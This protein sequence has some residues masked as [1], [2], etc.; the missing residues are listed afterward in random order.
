MK[1][2]NICKF[3]MA[4]LELKSLTIT[5]FVRET[6]EETMSRAVRLADN[7]MLLCTCGS[8]I[9]SIDGVKYNIRSGSL[10]VC[11][12]GEVVTVESVDGL[13]Y[14]YIGFTGMRS[15]ELFRRFDITPISRML[16]G[17]DGLIPLWQESLFSAMDENLDIVAE[18]LLLFSFSRMHG[19]CGRECGVISRIVEMTEE[20]FRDCNVNISYIADK[21]SYN[22]KYLSHLF[23]SKTGVGYSEYLRSVRLK[24]ATALFDRGIDSVKSVAQLSGFSDPFYFSSVFKK[25]VGMSPKEYLSARNTDEQRTITK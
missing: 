24:F 19:D 10:L 2:Q 4:A 21:L 15:A 5:C 12:A 8:G 3:P 6:D 25:S 17:F 23:K 14:I 11:M 13:V 20:S 16:S 18:S 1:N 7:R 22:P 9:V